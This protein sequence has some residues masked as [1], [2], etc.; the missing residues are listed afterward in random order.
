MGTELLVM[1]ALLAL[2][3]LAIR[4][5][6]DREK[7]RFG[8][9][10]DERQALLRGR[11]YRAGF[12]TLMAWS[13]LMHIA[14]TAGAA[15]PFE[16]DAGWMLGAF[17][18]FAVFSVYCVWNDAFFLRTDKLDQRFLTFLLLGGMWVFKGIRDAKTILPVENGKLTAGAFT[19]LAG[20]LMLLIPATAALRR[21]LR[22]DGDED[23]D[24]E[25]TK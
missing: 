25:G 7:A 14:A 21:I 2:S 15:L 23:D 5:L 6:A 8:E 24:K 10:Y 17:F 22:R 1:L 12:Y 11:G 9:S 4:I 18:G 20:I 19:I 3:A 16:R 13:V